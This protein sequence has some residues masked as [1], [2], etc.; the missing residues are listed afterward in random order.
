[1][2][3]TIESFLIQHYGHTAVD[4]LTLLAESGSS[5]KYYRFQSVE[6]SMILTESRNIAE[7]QAFLYFT[8]HFSSVMDCLPTIKKVSED[9]S[10][11]VQSD[12]GDESLLKLLMENPL[13]AKAMF[14]KSVI[15]LAQMQVLGDQNLDYSR[16]FSYPNFNYLMVL[17]DLFSF[18][19][20][21]LNLVGIEMNHRELLKDFERFALDF[22]QIPERY[23]VFRDFQSRNIMIH[24]DRPFFIDYQGGMK[25]PVQYDLVSLLW[26]AKA[27]LSIEWKNELYALYVEEFTRLKTGD[28]DSHQF[29]KG[30]ELCLIERLLQVL[31]TYGFRGIYERKSHFLESISYAL[32]NLTDIQDLEI[33]NRYPE[34]KKVIQILANQEHN[35]KF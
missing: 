20:Y 31:G 18:K 7:N 29:Q 35:N 3:A 30:Y 2:Q 21:Y 4:T 1:M 23:F 15:Q 28:F 19:N 13:K 26:Q 32:R 17:R 24:Q 34:L 25:G 27:N 10:L 14:E 22:E 12:L 9:G 33:L 6:T 5:R 16:C 11:Y 8:Q